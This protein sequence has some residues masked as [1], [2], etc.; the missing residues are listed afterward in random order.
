MA[1]SNKMQ[2]NSMCY[3]QDYLSKVI[4]RAD[5]ESGLV[6]SLAERSQFSDQIALLFP[7][8][9][10]LSM[11]ELQ[12]EMGEAGSN[13]VKQLN[14]GSQ[15]THR[16]SVDGTAQACLGPG[17]LTLEYGPGDYESFDAFF[18]EFKVLI[19]KLEEC[20]GA[21]DL[22]RIGLRYVNEI[23]LPGRA[24]DWK[25]IIRPE[26]VAAVLA[27]AVTGGRLLRSMHQVVELHDEDQI[28][29]NYGIFNPD[30]PAPVVQRFF[31][32]DIDCSRAGC[33][34]VA[35]ALSCVKQLNAH[36]TATFEAS[37]DGG[38]RETMGV[39]ENE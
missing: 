1:I 10:S 39:K 23:R 11:M 25:G 22:N 34:P 2:S 9:S 24:L 17:H 6:G 19:E 4:L 3:R 13:D 29:F 30:F 16:K 21:F 33:I 18:N 12:I 5:F 8:V 38:L 35:E 20:F 15:W 7:H 37:I 36:A 28:L 32:L 14:K 26:L 31:I 27:P